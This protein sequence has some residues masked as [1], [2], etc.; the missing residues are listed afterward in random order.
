MSRQILLAH[1]I[2]GAMGADHDLVAT[3]KTL[4]TSYTDVAYYLDQALQRDH[5]LNMNAFETLD[6]LVDGGA[7]HRPMKE[8]A[9]DMYLSQSA[10]SRTVGR[11]ERDG[12]VART[13]SDSDRRVVDVSV[14]DEGRRRHA[15][16][17]VT[18]LAV[19]TEHL[20]AMPTRTESPLIGHR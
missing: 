18:R 3:W 12:L 8:L 14:T 9:H 13:V 19:L 16:A 5:D 11:L 1:D 6:R 15:E 17:S 7:D 10:L 20:R 2:L 4:L